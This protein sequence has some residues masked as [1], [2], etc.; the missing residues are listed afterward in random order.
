MIKVQFFSTAAFSLRVLKLILTNIS[1]SNFERGSFIRF[2][3]L[4]FLTKFKVLAFHRKLRTCCV[5]ATHAMAS[6]RDRRIEIA[7]IS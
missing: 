5:L 1:M 2:K 6:E 3:A 4:N 7:Q